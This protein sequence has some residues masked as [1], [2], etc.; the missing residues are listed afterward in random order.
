M[1]YYVYAP[2]GIVRKYPYSLADL[3]S[4]HPYTSF[5][6][7]IPDS[8]AADFDVFPV[9]DTPVPTYNP[10]AENLIWSDPVL[11]DGIWVQQWA[12]EDATP[13][14]IA[15]RELQAQQA[16]KAQAQSLLSAT[17]WTDIPAV[18]D[19]ANNPHLVNRDEFNAYRLQ[20]RGIAVN[21]PVTVDPWPVQPEEIWA[22]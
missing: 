6:A 18:S 13:E 16:N 10:I 1:S 11:V 4:D 19:P 3:V 15:E 14:E 17:D 12:V 21:P 2:N 9:K 7:A 5:P 22:S 8:L 20:L